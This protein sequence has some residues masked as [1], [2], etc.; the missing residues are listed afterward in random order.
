MSKQEL[1][2]TDE[3]RLGIFAGYYSCQAVDISKVSFDEY[4]CQAQ[5]AKAQIL[6]QQGFK[7]GLAEGKRQEGE[8]ILI[9]I[10]KELNFIEMSGITTTCDG[11]LTQEYIGFKLNMIE[12]E[13]GGNKYV[14]KN[15]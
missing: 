9:I 15:R 10:R 14:D 12:Q 8:R 11:K 13:L 3:E 5:L 4:L 7:Q 2:L 1:L 6:K